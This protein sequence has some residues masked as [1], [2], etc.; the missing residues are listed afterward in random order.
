MTELFIHVETALTV[1]DK[2]YGRTPHFRP[3]HT[4][5][6]HQMMAPDERIVTEEFDK[7]H[8]KACQAVEDSF[9]QQVTKFPHSENCK[10]YKV[11]Q[12]GSSNW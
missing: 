9:C 11:T 3:H 5:A 8:R 12:G 7:K 4:E 10:S 1:T 6:E 2:A